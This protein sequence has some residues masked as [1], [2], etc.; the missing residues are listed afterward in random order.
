M[1]APTAGEASDLALLGEAVAP[2]DNAAILAEEQRRL[3]ELTQRALSSYRGHPFLRW[4]VAP[5]Q[6]APLTFITHMFLHAGWLH[7]LGNLLILYLA[8]PFVE[9]VWGRP[10]FLGF[11]LISGIVAALFFVAPLFITLLSIPLLGEKVGVRRISAVI[12]GFLGVLVMVR[13]GSDISSGVDNWLVLLLPVIAALAYAHARGVI[14]RDLK[15]ENII[16]FEDNKGSLHPKLVDFGVAK[17]RASRSPSSSSQSEQA[18]LSLVG[19]PAS[20]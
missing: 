5:E 18:E 2:P 4:G 15:P 11:Y 3:D 12:V 8:G 1:L 13:P 9:D 19:T 17:L 14:H 20:R 7:L 10:L 16:I 6:R